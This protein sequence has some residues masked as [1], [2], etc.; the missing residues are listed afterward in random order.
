MTQASGVDREAGAWEIYR[1]AG[2]N[3]DA[4]EKIILV[5]KNLLFTYESDKRVC[6]GCSERM[7]EMGKNKGPYC[8]GCT[9]CNEE[10]GKEACLL[11][12]C[13]FKFGCKEPSIAPCQR[14]CFWCKRTIP[15]NMFY[16]DI[17][18]QDVELLRQFGYEPY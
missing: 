11:C 10:R 1:D 3:K 14:R 4:A 13:K 18:H 12:G 2:E 16:E 5:S 17:T 8:L 15:E 9:K 7:T 6:F